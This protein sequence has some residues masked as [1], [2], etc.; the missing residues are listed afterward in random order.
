MTIETVSII[1]LGALG[2][3]FAEQLQQQMPAE[4]LRIVANQARIDRY[5]ESGIFCNGERCDFTYV[6]ADEAT[7]PADMVL[8]CVKFHQLEAAMH[9]ARHQI[10]DNTLIVSALNGIRSEQ[11]LGERFGHENIIYSVSQGMD[12]LKSGNQVTY[13]NAGKLVIGAMPNQNNAEQV[14]RLADFFAKTHFP[15][16]VTEDIQQRLWG[17]LMVNV[18]VNQT[19]GLYEGTFSTVQRPGP[20]RELY[21]AAM[22]EVMAVAK[23]EGVVIS[24]DDLAYWINIIDQLDPDGMPSLRQ[25]LHAGRQTELALFAGTIIELGQ[26]HQI[27]TPVNEKL[28]EGIR[29]LE[30][31]A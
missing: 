19:V 3:L 6:S 18:G 4:N 23:P 5:R 13:Q 20:A 22:R 2:V 16:Q 27:P 7:Q 26:K 15:H 25:D 17:K 9:D 29:K 10:G 30:A 8:F 28:H 1:G 14:Q 11:V 21:I 12:A 31:N 24:E